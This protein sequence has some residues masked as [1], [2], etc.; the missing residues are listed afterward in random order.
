[1]RGLK[2]K[3]SGKWKKVG[4]FLI[5]FLILIFLSNS[6]NNVYQKKK[7]ADMALTRM[8][9]RVT[10]LQNREEVLKQSL[11]R[12]DTED[13]MK[14]EIRKKL[15]VAQAGESVAVIVDPEQK[16]PVPSYL[17]S[18]WQKFKNFFSWLFQ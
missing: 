11:A 4:I 17:I 14:F 12:L 8:K 9:E 16:A 6:L 15:N 5:L 3:E 10:D 1:M 13:G 7:N 2:H 18:P